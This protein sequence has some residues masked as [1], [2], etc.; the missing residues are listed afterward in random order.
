MS[1]IETAARMA[2]E[3]WAQ[4]LAE[5][6]ADRRTSQCQTPKVSGREPRE[7]SA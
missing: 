3:W 1:Q 7:R 6:F 2:G 4:R 5:K